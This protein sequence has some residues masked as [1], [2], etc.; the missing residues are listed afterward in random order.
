MNYSNNNLSYNNGVLFEYID[1]MRSI[2]LSKYRY[3]LLFE[4][5]KNGDIKVL[6]Y[7]RGFTP[8]KSNNTQRITM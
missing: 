8:I 7:E 1:N 4:R 6:V 3:Q 2:T 5:E